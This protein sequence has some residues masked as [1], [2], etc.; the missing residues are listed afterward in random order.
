MSIKYLFRKVR[1]SVFPREGRKGTG[2][3]L[4]FKCGFCKDRFRTLSQ[5]YQHAKDCTEGR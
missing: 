1:D 5:R 4:R 2:V 3:S